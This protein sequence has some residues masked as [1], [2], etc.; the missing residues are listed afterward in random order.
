M[1]LLRCILPLQFFISINWVDNLDSNKIDIMKFSS[2]TFISGLHLAVFWICCF[3]RR[4]GF[5]S[6]GHTRFTQKHAICSFE[7]VYCLNSQTHNRHIVAFEWALSSPLNAHSWV[8]LIRWTLDGQIDRECAHLVMNYWK[9]FSA[10]KLKQI[11]KLNP[12]GRVSGA[13]GESKF[14]KQPVTRYIQGYFFT[15][16]FED[17]AQTC[18]SLRLDYQPNECM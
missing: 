2:L 17:E 12:D 15:C 8:I 10:S 18:P 4:F 11:I 3:L 13:K 1:Q 5:L 16:V 7:Y 6:I 14:L 9:A